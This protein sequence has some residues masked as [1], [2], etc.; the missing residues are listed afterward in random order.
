MKQKLFN[1]IFKKKMLGILFTFAKTFMI[2]LGKSMDNIK[3]S[4][5]F[6]KIFW[7]F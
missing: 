1:N 3:K 4:L 7:E 6:K 5:H 2:I